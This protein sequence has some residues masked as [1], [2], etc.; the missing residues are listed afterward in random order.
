MKWRGWSVLLLFFGFLAQAEQ[1]PLFCGDLLIAPHFEVEEVAPRIFHLKFDDQRNLAQTFMR[2]Q[3]HY[4]SPEFRG[5]IFSRSEYKKWYR[6]IQGQ[7]S[8]YGDWAGF[9]IPSFVL[10][11]FYHGSFKKLT[12]RER[13]ILANFSHLREERFYIIGTFELDD[14]GTLLHEIAHGLFYTNETYRE[15]V[16]KILKEVDIEPILSVLRGPGYHEAVLVDETHA[17]L[18]T[19]LEHLEK[20]GVN[21]ENYRETIERLNTL[22]KQYFNSIEN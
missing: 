19:D 5:K 10:D 12:S 22:F 14:P 20:S 21:L 6:K 15:E 11:A 2:F 4:E 16:L 13:A 17:Y 1:A 3:E 9:N 7:F 8:Y 18:L